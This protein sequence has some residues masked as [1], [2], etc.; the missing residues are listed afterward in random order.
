M[1][2]LQLV[3]L[4]AGVFFVSTPFP[5]HVKNLETEGP[6]VV[7]LVSFRQPFCKSCFQN[8]NTRGIEKLAI[9]FSK[10][11]IRPGD[12]MLAIAVLLVAFILELE[13]SSIVWSWPAR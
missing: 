8:E 9:F 6:G 2:W 12:E 10:P 11:V 4:G 5:L 7:E 1:Q 3:F 13:N